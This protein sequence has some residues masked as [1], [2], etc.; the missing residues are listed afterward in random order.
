MVQY[1]TWESVM[2]KLEVTYSGFSFEKEG[3][4]AF[5]TMFILAGYLCV[6]KTCLEKTFNLNWKY[7][8]NVNITVQMCKH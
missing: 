7:C 8:P 1:E 3:E 4:D 2:W 5:L 6:L